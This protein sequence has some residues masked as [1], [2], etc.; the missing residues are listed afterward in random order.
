[1]YC[2]SWQEAVE[3]CNKRS[4][5]E[6]LTPAYSGSGNEIRCNLSASG[7]RLPTEA[8]WEWAARGG[9]KDPLE[10][11]YSGSNSADAVAWYDGNSGN[12]THPVGAKR[13]NSLGLYDMSGNVWEW[14]W[15]WF[16]SYSGNA[17]TDPT[18]VASGSYRVLRG[19]GWYFSAG[20]PRSADRGGGTPTNRGVDLGFRVVR[21]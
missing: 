9:G 16:G 7:Y 14:C 20:S 13:P 21:P 15:D 2:V 1:M 4:V 10:Y 17:Q 18:G 3:Y 11:T 5:K 6:G 19:G 12:T 8:E